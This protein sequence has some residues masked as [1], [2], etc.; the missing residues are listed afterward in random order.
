MTNTKELAKRHR[1][2][3]VCVLS[4][5][6]RVKFSLQKRER[7]P[8]YRACFSGPDG[9]RK[10]RTTKEKNRKRAFDAATAI[11]RDEFAPKIVGYRPT[12]EEAIEKMKRH[13][14]AANLR[15]T[16]IRRYED[17]LTPFR[18]WADVESPAD[19]TPETA[20]QYKIFRIDSGKS[21]ATVESDLNNLRVIYR[22]WWIKT[23]R[24]L[25]SN[26]FDSVEPP[27]KEKWKPRVLSDDEQKAFLDWLVQRW[28]NWRLPI[29]F[30][31]VKARIGARI[32]ELASATPDSLRDGRIYFT[33]E[34]TKGRKQRGCKLP[35]ALYDELKGVAV[36]KFIFGNFSKELKAIHL[37]RN[38]P[39]SANL[40]RPFTPA[41]LVRWLQKQPKLFQE[42]TGCQPFK[43]HNFRGTA[44]SRARRAGASYDD[45]SIAFG[46]QPETMRKHYVAEEEE[47]IAD[48]VMDLI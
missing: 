38:W 23:I 25:T 11:I 32:T 1:T 34:T 15:P 26:P 10:E 13:M 40:V 7:D 16:T 12:W 36:E 24:L 30:L 2:N 22:K 17:A 33:A 8:V 20:E 9:K 41:R 3:E 19:V 37:R 31:E 5:G 46:C 48:A 47:A 28:D 45:A 6:Q 18:N 44:M 21:V 14:E 27:K 42:E 35:E 39:Q 43:L 4:D 29:L